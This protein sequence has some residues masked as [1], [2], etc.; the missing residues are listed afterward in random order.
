M[1][2]PANPDLERRVL[3]VLE[4]M[5]AYRVEFFSSLTEALEGR[6][7]R[8]LVAHGEPSDDVAA[9][10]DARDLPGA[11]QRPSKLLRLGSRNL[12]WQ[13]FRTEARRCD[14]AVLNEGSRFL[15]NYVLLVDQFRRRARV[16]FW[17]N[18]ANLNELE[19]SWIAERIKRPLYRLPHWYFA[20]TEG[21]RDRIG[22]LGFPAERISVVQNTVS[23][24]TLRREIGEIGAD[25]VDDMRTDLGL[26]G[27]VLG[28][29]LGSLHAA[30]RLAFLLAAADQI[31]A[32]RPDFALVIAGD[33]PDRNKVAAQVAQ[34]PYARMVGRVD[35][36]RKAALLSAADLLLLPGGIG[37]NIVEG[38]AAGVPTVS[39]ALPT[40]APEVEY[41][42]DGA[43]GRMLPAD[44]STRQ[45]AQ[46]V[47]GLLD[48]PRRLS[49]LS[50]GAAES[51]AIYTNAAMVG[52]V[53]DGIVKAVDG[54]P[55]QSS[56]QDGRPA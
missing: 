25:A 6:G 55:T 4:W 48:Q 18:G 32:A 28:L 11:I 46:A 53:A 29:F 22:E 50:R 41:L 36:V 1:P 8:L 31:A 24:E 45:Y 19:A 52:R 39:T 13:P 51:A 42:T 27:G 10:A 26:D 14:L 21:S 40:H 5:P 30:R 20:Y 17:G 35:G 47:V 15:L 9:R 37:L 38:F 56:F 49:I 33:G 54:C 23:T 44:T 3:F 43:N 2:Y 16:A 12:V 7:I 34:R